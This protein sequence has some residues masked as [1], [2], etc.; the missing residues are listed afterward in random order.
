MQSK[1][2][3]RLILTVIAAAAGFALFLLLLPLEAPFLL[4]LLTALICERAVVFLCA[5]LR[6]SRGLSAF[7][8]VLAFYAALAGAVWFAC[9]LLCGELA[10]FIRQLP[11]LLTSLSGPLEHLQKRL[12]ALADRLPDG[13]GTGLHEGLEHLFESGPLLAERAYQR[14]FSFASELFSKVPRIFLFII[15]T[16]LSGFMFSAELPGLRSVLKKRLPADFSSKAGALWGRVKSAFGG[17]LLAQLK[18]MGITFVWMTLGLMLL[19]VDYPFLFALLISFVDALP[20]FG[21][22]VI[23]IPWSLLS[24][25]RGNTASGIGFLILYAAA[26]LTRQ[27]LEPRLVGRHIGLHPLV[28]LASFYVGFRL[29]GVLGIVL[30]PLAAIVLKQLLEAGLQKSA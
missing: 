22:G 14:L 25:L 29:F 28:T 4:G 15:T 11:S 2:P 7:F 5:R 9:R 30:F 18:L 13:L 3:V 16:I 17:W 27:T 12:F 23:L 1:K 21:T 24:F 19:R 10:G 26:A 6:L 20:V 8:C